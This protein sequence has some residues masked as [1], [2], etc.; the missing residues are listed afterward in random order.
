MSNCGCKESNL[1]PDPI[2]AKCLDYSGDLGSSTTITASCVDQH[3]VNEDLYSIVDDINGK[4]DTSELGDLSIT[5]PDTGGVIS[6]KDVIAQYEIEIDALKTKVTAL[7]NTLAC[8]LDITN[9]D[10]SFGDLV[11]PCGEPITTL[12]QALQVLFNQ[13]T[14]S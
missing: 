9:C 14:V 6:F 4:L 3:M 7:E 12:G 1:C 11:D 8:N 13:H 5:F 10:I 2:D